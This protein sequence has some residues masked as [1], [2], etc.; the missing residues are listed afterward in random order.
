[1]RYRIPLNNIKRLFDEQMEKEK[2]VAAF[3]LTRFKEKNV[4]SLCFEVKIEIISLK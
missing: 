1:M 3:S 2:M 4:C